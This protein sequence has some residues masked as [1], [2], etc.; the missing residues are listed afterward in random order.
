[1]DVCYFCFRTF[2]AAF[3]IVHEHP[4]LR[5]RYV[6]AASLT[7][8]LAFLGYLSSIKGG[9]EIASFRVDFLGGLKAS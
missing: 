7:V 8:S 9:H 2:V 4:H 6:S 5:R 3:M 1:M